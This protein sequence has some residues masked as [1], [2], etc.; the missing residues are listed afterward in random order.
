SGKAGLA[1]ASYVSLLANALTACMLY[2]VLVLLSWQITLA[3]TAAFFVLTVGF[4]RLSRHAESYGQI[5]QR[6]FRD[7]SSFGSEVILGIRQ[8]KVFSA[9]TRMRKKFQELAGQITEVK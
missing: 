6:L 4:Q 1:V 8:I 9:E 2:G 7:L 3:A 5:N